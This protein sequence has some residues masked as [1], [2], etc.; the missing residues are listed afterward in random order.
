MHPALGVSQHPQ[1]GV[2]DK[3]GRFHCQQP[4]LDTIRTRFDEE[5]LVANAGVASVFPQER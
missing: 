2:L 5:H 4:S 3:A 1:A